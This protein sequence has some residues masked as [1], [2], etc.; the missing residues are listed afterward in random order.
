MIEALKER[1]KS[2]APFWAQTFLRGLIQGFHWLPSG[3]LS[4]ASPFQFLEENLIIMSLLQSCLKAE[5]VS[6]TTV[7]TSSWALMITLQRK[8]LLESDAALHLSAYER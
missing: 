3:A 6:G 5:F 2:A 1:Q 7:V 8:Q 4:S